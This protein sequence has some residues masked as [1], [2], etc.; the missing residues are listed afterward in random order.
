MLRYSIRSSNFQIITN[1]SKRLSHVDYN[2]ISD[3]KKQKADP[4]SFINIE[5][6]GAEPIGTTQADYYQ[7]PAAEKVKKE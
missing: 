5:K 7:V 6:K 1:L 3:D 2:Q 4:S